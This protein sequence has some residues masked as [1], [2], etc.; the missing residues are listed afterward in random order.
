VYAVHFPV[1]ATAVVGGQEEEGETKSNKGKEEGQETETESEK[2]QVGPEV[3]GR[4]KKTGKKRGGEGRE[5]FGRVLAL[6]D[7]CTAVVCVCVCVCV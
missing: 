1:A 4:T 7:T 5:E 3:T 2:G 6:R